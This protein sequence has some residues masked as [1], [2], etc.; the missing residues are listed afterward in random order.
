MNPFG[1]LEHLNPESLKTLTAPLRR[2]ITGKLWLQVLIAMILGVGLGLVLSPDTGWVSRSTASAIGEWISLPG[3]LFLAFIQMIV[4]PLILASIIQGIA[5]ASDVQQLKSTGIWLGVYF[6]AATMMATVIGIT[7]ALA[8]RP[9]AYVDAEGLM[10]RTQKASGSSAQ[11]IERGVEQTAAE[12]EPF[13][14]SD[15]PGRVTE[16]LPTNPMGAIAQGD[17][18]QIVIFAIVLGLGLVSLQPRSA[19]PLL[20]L[21]GSVQSVCMAVVGAVMTFAPIAVFGLLAQAMIKT[22]PGVLAGLGIYAGAVV[23]GMALLLVVYLIVVA[24]LGGRN[25]LRFFIGIREAFLLAFST[26]SSA[27]TMPITVKSAEEQLHVRPSIAQLVV[28]LG[29]T[30]N[31]GGTALYQG[32]ATLFMAQMFDMELSVSALLAL[33]VTALGASIGTP[34]VPGV[35][36][37]VLATV[38]SSAGVPL[39]GLALIIGLDQVLERF[40]TSLNVTGDLVACVVMDRFMPAKRSREEEVRQAEALEKQ[41]QAESAETATG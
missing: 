12:R 23:L 28:P 16:I 11:A 34:A 38:L 5:G 41:R 31:M 18:L 6:L 4:V 20:D 29:A 39:G 19:R 9:G 10:G 2:L 1:A 33:V 15:I 37:I 22:G 36:I 7:V 21:F 35:G 17:M 25:P 30:V 3:H 32:L 24:T 13:S 14:I 40:R 26:N 27:A 8:L